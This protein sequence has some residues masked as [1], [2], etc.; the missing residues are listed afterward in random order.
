MIA[1]PTLSVTAKIAARTAFCVAGAFA[2]SVCSRREIGRSSL[3]TTHG[4]VRWNTMTWSASFAT[5]GIS[6]IAL[7]PVPITPMRLPASGT[8]WFHCAEWNRPP[9]K[10]ARPSMSG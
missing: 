4:A 2:Y 10:S 9:W 1:T 5:R 8:S 7:A 6:W 3:G